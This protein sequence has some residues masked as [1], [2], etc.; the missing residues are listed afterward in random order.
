MSSIIATTPIT[1]TPS[2][3]T[4]SMIAGLTTDQSNLAAIEQQVS[5]GNAINV[6]SDNPAGAATILQLQGSV[7]RANQ[8]SANAADGVGWLSLGNSTVGSVLNVLQSIKSVV[9]GVSGSSLLGSAATITSTAQQVQ[10]A[11]NQLIDLANTTEEGGQPIFAGTGNA[12]QAY[13]LT[14]TTGTPPVTYATYVGNST[15]PTRTVAP[16]TRV[17]IAATGPDVFGASTVTTGGVTTANPAEL[18]GQY[19]VLNTMIANLGTAAADLSSGNS[20]G[21]QAAIGQV[22]GAGLTNLTTALA[23]AETAAGVLGANQDSVQNFSTQ[24]TASLTAVQGELSSVQDTNVAQALTN[25]Q[26]QQAAYQSALYATA[27]LSSDTLV[28]YL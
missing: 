17:A 19:G 2:V 24:A 6:A 11:L 27:Q 13:A 4:S 14:T 23:H 26:L 28:K 15:A 25:L 16:G 22:T 20:T 5:T 8:Y 21:A 10:S 9:E 1:I 18:L 12:T 3:L 7:T